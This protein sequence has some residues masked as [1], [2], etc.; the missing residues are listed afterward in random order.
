MKLSEP[1][2]PMIP[3]AIPVSTYDENIRDRR[4]QYW[5]V[6]VITVIRLLFSARKLSNEVSPKRK[7]PVRNTIQYPVSRVMK[8]LAAVDCVIL[9]SSR[10]IAGPCYQGYYS[11]CSR[12]WS[13]FRQEL[14]LI[15]Y[16]TCRWT[17]KILAVT[18]YNP[19][20]EQ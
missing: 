14:L 3:H 12:Y 1:K 18:G 5:Q 4:M 7:R 16:N 10:Q 20:F 13:K 2:L 9:T 17:M 15:L 11:P 6:F 19:A 8:I